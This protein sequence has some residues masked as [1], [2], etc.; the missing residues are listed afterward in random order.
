[1][2]TAKV[3]LYD[4]GIHVGDFT[5]KQL[6]DRLGMAQDTLYRHLNNKKP[7]KKR[8]RLEYIESDTSEA[9]KKVKMQLLYQYDWDRL[10]IRINPAARR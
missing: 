6:K 8:W 10:R 5:I 2:E 1:M 3:R 7:I 4:N 9:G